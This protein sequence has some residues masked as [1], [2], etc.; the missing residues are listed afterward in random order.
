MNHRKFRKLINRHGSRVWRG[1]VGV[2]NNRRLKNSGNQTQPTGLSFVS[3]QVAGDF[4]KTHPEIQSNCHRCGTSKNVRHT[5]CSAQK[6][7]RGFAFITDLKHCPEAALLAAISYL[8]IDNSDVCRR[9]KTV[10]Q[11][12]TTDM[13]DGCADFLII[14]VYD[15]A[16]LSA[17]FPENFY[18]FF[19]IRSGVEKNSKCE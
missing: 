12:F 6:Y 11:N 19:K 18:F 5:D 14:N 1:I 16:T 17:K 7:R 4:F 10:T 15:S 2:V 3:C 9:I 8:T 13:R